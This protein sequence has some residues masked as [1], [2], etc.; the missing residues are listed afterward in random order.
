MH[1]EWLM[2]NSGEL[3]ERA[4]IIYGGTKGWWY[5]VN[6]KLV[7]QEEYDLGSFRYACKKSLEQ[8][9]KDK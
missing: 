7:S 6:G 8:V 2:K 4:M 9:K 3:I 5:S 1:K